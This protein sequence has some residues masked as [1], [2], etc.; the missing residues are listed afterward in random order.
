MVCTCGACQ[1][2]NASWEAQK[3]RMC[4]D[5]RGINKVTKADAYPLPNLQET[6]ALLGKSRFFTKIDLVA[7][8]HQIAMHPDSAEKTAFSVLGRHF[9][10]A[11]MPFGLRNAPAT[12]QRAINNVLDGL[13][14]STCLVYLDDIVVFAA[15]VEE[16]LERLQQVLDRLR[17][18]NLRANLSKCEFLQE[19]TSY[20]G[21]RI[22]SEGIGMEYDKIQAV[23]EFPTPANVRQIQAFLGLAGFYRRFVPGFAEIAAPMTQLLRKGTDFDWGRTKLLPSASS[24]KR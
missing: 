3:W 8:Y 19:E 13:I 10:Y 23:M 20:L 14:G 12:F 2:E 15:T 11:K 1:E 4:I 22:S 16:H 6:I 24:R 5:Y 7:G 21:H 9:E 18:V 17:E